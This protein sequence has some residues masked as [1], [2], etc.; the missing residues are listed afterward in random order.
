MEILEKLGSPILI[1]EVCEDV[2]GPSEEAD[3]GENVS[4]ETE[5][6]TPHF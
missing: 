6:A 2:E 1:L 3:S 5:A 4:W